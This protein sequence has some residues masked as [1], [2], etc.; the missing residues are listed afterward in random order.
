MKN[1]TV[2]GIR[3]FCLMDDTFMN[4]AF[5]ENTECDELSLRIISDS[6]DTHVM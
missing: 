3:G 5:D 4:R 6:Y 2:C 1:C